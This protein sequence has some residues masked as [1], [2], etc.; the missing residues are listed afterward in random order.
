MVKACE[1]STEQTEIGMV[2]QKGLIN[3]DTWI[4]T[5][6]ASMKDGK[7]IYLR[8]EKNFRKAITDAQNTKS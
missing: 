5:P 3:T 1:I 2:K 8:S 6:D 4:F 7:V